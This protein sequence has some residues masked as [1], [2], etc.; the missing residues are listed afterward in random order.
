MSKSYFELRK[1]L[2]AAIHIT[3]A[4]SINKNV[5]EYYKYRSSIYDLMGFKELAKEDQV[6]Y[7]SL[8]KS[9]Y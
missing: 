4:I 9:T 5:I 3:K 6:I 2:K 7:K 1:Y 8:T